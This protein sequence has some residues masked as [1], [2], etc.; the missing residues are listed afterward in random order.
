MIGRS[1][2]MRRVIKTYSAIAATV[3]NNVGN[4]IAIAVKPLKFSRSAALDG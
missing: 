3:R 4:P 2:W 1:V